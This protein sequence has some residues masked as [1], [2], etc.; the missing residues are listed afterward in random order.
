MTTLL[1]LNVALFLPVVLAGLA[2]SWVG[3]KL[4]G[5]D[6]RRAGGGGGGA[7]RPFRPRWPSPVE[8]TRSAGPDDLARSA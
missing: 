4:A 2:A 7:E 8:P 6:D 3:W 5:P 1:I